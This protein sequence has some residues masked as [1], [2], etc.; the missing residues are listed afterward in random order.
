MTEIWKDVEGYEGDY[1]ISNFGRVKSFKSKLPYLINKFVNGGYYKL[2]LHKNGVAK[3][4]VCVHRLV[5]TAFIEN[6]NDK[7]FVNHID[8]NKLNNRADNLEW[9]T[10]K[11]NHEHASK[12]G[13]MERGEDRHCSKLTTQGVLEIRKLYE[14]EIN[15]SQRKLAEK[16]NVSQRLIWNI[17]NNKSWVHV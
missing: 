6:P 3:R 12:M 1:Q 8:G 15:I 16:Y 4:N 11:E 2:S 7:P 13:L 17:V 9:C 5:A 10:P 14:S